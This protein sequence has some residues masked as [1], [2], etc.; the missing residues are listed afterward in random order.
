[1]AIEFHDGPD[2]LK[3]LVASHGIK[4]EWSDDG[5]GRV[6]FRSQRSGVLNYWPH[7]GTVQC[8]GKAEPRAELE[9]IFSSAGMAVP[10]A[11][12]PK[13]KDGKT[14]IFVVQKCWLVFVTLLEVFWWFLKVAS[15]SGKV[16]S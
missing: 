10:A 5:N 7:K 11:T 13:P 15:P 8:Q 14:K 16:S 3:E 6:S 2:A 1:M 4:G 12:A 9:A